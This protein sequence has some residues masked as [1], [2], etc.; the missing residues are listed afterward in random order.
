MSMPVHYTTKEKGMEKY[1]ILQMKAFEKS[2]TFQKRINDQ[3]RKG[4]RALNLASG[5]AGVMVL[6]EKIE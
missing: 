1:V 2:E 5:S 6:F 4:Y 3:V